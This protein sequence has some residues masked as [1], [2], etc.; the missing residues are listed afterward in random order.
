MIWLW[1]YGATVIPAM[2]MSA[3]IQGRCGGTTPGHTVQVAIIVGFAW[4]VM[5]PAV[6]LVLLLERFAVLGEAKAA[7]ERLPSPVPPTRP[8][9]QSASTDP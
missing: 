1:A 9:E 5:L 6:G 7:T 2:C 3:Y 8:S 4:P